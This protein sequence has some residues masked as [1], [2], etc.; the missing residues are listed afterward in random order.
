MKFN[1]TFCL[2]F[3]LTTVL[4]CGCGEQEKMLVQHKTMIN[5]VVESNSFATWKESL[6]AGNFGEVTAPSIRGLSIRKGGADIFAVSYEPRTYKNSFDCWAISEPYQSMVTVDT[7]RM[8]ELF[9]TVA[10]MTMEPVTNVSHEDAGFDGRDDSIYVAYYSKQGEG[11]GQAEPDCDVWYRIGNQ[12]EDGRYYVETEDGIWLADR[13]SIEA[14]MTV[15][16]YDYILRIVNV[17]SIET[18]SEVEVWIE[19][20]IYRMTHQ[21]GKFMVNEAIIDEKDYYKLY[22][23][24]MSIF[25]EAEIEDM[26][27]I[28]EDTLMTVIYHRNDD[29]A[30]D[31]VQRYYEYDENMVAVE[32][33]GTRFFLVDKLALQSLIEQ[34]KA[35]I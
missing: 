6:R 18:V 17:V 5:E 33:N 35:L 25:I 32:V 29:T 22:S 10:G 9:E 3:L 23:D 1:R 8:Y 14:I 12:A 28:K 16:P 30:P 24:L 20:E 19:D 31:I 4:L 34:I 13:D 27:K 7:E 2:V 21:G 15:D 11:T 26:E